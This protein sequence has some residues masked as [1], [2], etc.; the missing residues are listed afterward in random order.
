MQNN[1]T[2]CLWMCI[3]YKDIH[4]NSKYQIQDSGYPL[5]ERREM[6]LDRITQRVSILF[7]MLLL[8]MHPHCIIFYIFLIPEIIKNQMEEQI[9]SLYTVIQDYII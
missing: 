4:R 8:L 2:Y 6:G 1:A 3:N 9:K 7:V 5:E